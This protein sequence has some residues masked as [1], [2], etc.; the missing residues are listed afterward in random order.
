M[1]PGPASITR[2]RRLLAGSLAGSLAILGL[3]WWG[4]SRGEPAAPTTTD[5]PAQAALVGGVQPAPIDSARF[6]PD[7]KIGDEPT[8]VATAPTPAPLPAERERWLADPPPPVQPDPAIEAAISAQEAATRDATA[9]LQDALEDRRGALARTCLNG[10]D[11]ANI[12]FQASFDEQ[13]KLTDHQVADNGTTTAV[14]DCVANQPFKMSIPR[15][16]AA[17][18][19][20]GTLS[21]P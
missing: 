14:K 6:D 10:V 4:L 18:R 3:V 2:S 1:S 16:G 17:V 11:S 8:L 15:T 21:L 13:G 12:F 9:A 20:R 5:A 7:P 19:V